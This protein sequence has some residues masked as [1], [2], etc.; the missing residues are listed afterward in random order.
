MKEGKPYA[1]KQLLAR[2]IPRMEF[3]P[4]AD[5]LKVWWSALPFLC[6]WK[7]VAEEGLEPPTRGL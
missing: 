4:D 7:M 1:V 5:R 3:D 2:L 6:R